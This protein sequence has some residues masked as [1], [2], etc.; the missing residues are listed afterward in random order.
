MTQRIKLLNIFRDALKALA[1]L[2]SGPTRYFQ[3]QNEE[4]LLRNAL[5]AIAPLAAAAGLLIFLADALSPAA[6]KEAVQAL[7]QRYGVE[8]PPE[9]AAG[10]SGLRALFFPLYWAGFVA[11]AGACCL[12]MARLLDDRDANFRISAL[13]AAHAA[14]PL[15]ASG[16]V[17][18]VLN[19][20]FPP[21]L[22]PAIVGVVRLVINSL[23]VFGAWFWSTRIAMS[24]FQLHF[25][26]N[27][28]RA[29]LTWLAPWFLI[30]VIAVLF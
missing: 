15:M 18:G 1:A 21:F 24:G 16:L 11:L 10:S 22:N 19:A 17:F 13:I 23:T 9:N 28:G 14:L 7:L 27:A 5:F 3:E 25:K 6:S 26:Q 4:A 29:A 30:V 2:V 12:G 20:V 8:N